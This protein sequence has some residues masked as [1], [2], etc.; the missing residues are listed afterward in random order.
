[1]KRF[2]VLSIHTLYLVFAQN[3]YRKRLQELF[4]RIFLGTHTI[5]MVPKYICMWC[6]MS[7]GFC[8][9]LFIIILYSQKY[10]FK[11][12]AVKESCEAY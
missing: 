2:L 12:K 5:K 6:C 8:L 9:C 10:I 1:M 11:V 7:I 4:G 3:I